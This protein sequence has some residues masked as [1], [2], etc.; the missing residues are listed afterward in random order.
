[1]DNKKRVLSCLAL[2]LALL[3]FWGMARGVWRVQ[4]N[5]Q[6]TITA[7]S[8]GKA[9]ALIV[10]QGRHTVVI[11]TGE[12]EGAKQ[13]QT[14]R[15]SGM[16]AQD[17]APTWNQAWGAL[18]VGAIPGTALLKCPEKI[19]SYALPVGYPVEGSYLYRMEED[20]RIEKVTLCGTADVW[21]PCTTG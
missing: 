19:D 11:D 4:E 12:E 3:V 9:D 15:S 5:G 16:R 6:L 18:N 14:T 13:L 10:Q 2:V 8:I 1:M 7:L 17:G 21:I 20:E